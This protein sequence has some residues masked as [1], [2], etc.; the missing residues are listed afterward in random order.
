MLR[1][2]VC[3]ILLLCLCSAPSMAQNSVNNGGGLPGGTNGQIQKNNS[4]IF[5]GITLIPLANGGA[6]ADLSGTGGTSQVLKQTSAGGNISVARLAC[7]DLSDSQSGC[8]SASGGSTGGSVTNTTPVTATANTTSDQALMELAMSAG[9]LNSSGQPFYINGAGIY[10][11]PA[12]QT[13]TL[14]FKIKLCTVSGCGSGTVV[15][16]ASIV[17]TAT[18][19]SVTNNNWNVHAVAITTTTGA[20]GN[21]EVHGP[22]TVDLG[23]LTTSEDSVFGDTNTAVS[24]NIDLTAALFIDF[25]VATS[26]GSASNSI[27]QRSGGIM[28]FAATGAPVTSVFGLTGAVMSAATPADD[29]VLVGDSATAATW[30]T[31]SNNQALKYA[32]ASNTFSQAAAADLSDGTTGSTTIVLSTSPTLT[33]PRMATIKDTGGNP[34]FTLTATASAVDGLT[35]TNAATANPA[36]VTVATSGSDSNVN[37]LLS[38]KGTGKFQLSD[39]TDTTKLVAFDVAGATT[40]K[41]LTI[42]S[43]FTLDRT[44]TVP[45]ASTTIPV[46]TQVLTFSG[47]TAARTYTL[48]DASTTVVGL[49]DTQTLTNKRVS[50]R[51]TTGGGACDTTSATTITPAGDSCDSY[52]VTA[53][54]TNPT[55]AAPSGTPTDQ[56]RLLLRIKDNATARTLTWDAIY[57]ASTDLALPTVTVISKTMYLM[58]VYNATDTKWDFVA[59]LNNF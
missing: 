38:P 30:R 42:A 49:T 36:T 8:S 32:T 28:P 18:L 44:L 43:S 5:G 31:L 23:S 57:R 24:S 3:L 1:Q 11:T 54:A 6:N 45:D 12:G 34:V 47:P 15:T 22:L 7:A 25:T 27:T 17:S 48:P 55:F 51:V 58:F 14:T 40:A 9:F 59:F 19:A 33:T 4:G 20:S 41:K 21:L 39:G 50:P 46:A 29:K 37:L 2:I 53:L 16:L 13:P 56:Q 10:T 52:L 26:T 35:V